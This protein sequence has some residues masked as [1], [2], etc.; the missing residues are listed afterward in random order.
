MQTQIFLD[1]ARVR[2]E[3]L[4]RLSNRPERLMARE[5]ER[6]RERRFR[7]SRRRVR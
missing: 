1:A 2:D 7:L 6:T 5:L 3:E 4:R